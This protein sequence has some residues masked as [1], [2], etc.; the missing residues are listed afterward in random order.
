MGEKL[1]MRTYGL[2]DEDIKRAYATG[3]ITKTECRL[4]GIGSPYNR[5]SI[6]EVAAYAKEIGAKRWDEDPVYQLRRVRKRIT[7]AQED[8]DRLKGELED[9]KQRELDLT[10][11]VI[12][13]PK[14]PRNSK[15]KKK[16]ADSE[17]EQQPSETPNANSIEF[18][19]VQKYLNDQEMNFLAGGTTA[20]VEEQEELFPIKIPESYTALIRQSM[21]AIYYPR[22]I[23]VNMEGGNTKLGRLFLLALN[24]LLESWKQ[25]PELLKELTLDEIMSE[26]SWLESSDY[27]RSKIESVGQQAFVDHY[28]RFVIPKSPKDIL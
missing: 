11:E 2:K 5:V 27:M 26:M 1:A 20:A 19:E 18:D 13:L 23:W 28:N 3:K 7:K 25:W 21:P 6:R 8:L 14:K 22:N 17:P 12:R 4:P 9:L 15:K 10:K 24:R 16:A